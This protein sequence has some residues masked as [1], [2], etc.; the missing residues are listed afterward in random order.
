MKAFV[1]IACAVVLWGIATRALIH[2]RYA[3]GLFVVG[4]AAYGTWKLVRGN[5]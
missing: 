3:S 4:I 2:E 1:D 5:R